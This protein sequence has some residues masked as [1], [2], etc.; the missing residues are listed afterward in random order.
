M[1]PE[2]GMM[3]MVGIEPTLE[4]IQKVFETFASAN[5]ATSPGIGCKVNRERKRILA[6]EPKPRQIDRGSM[7][8]S[9]CN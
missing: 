9:G 4:V 6:G 8:L 2:P 3:G 1:H 7:A 5:S